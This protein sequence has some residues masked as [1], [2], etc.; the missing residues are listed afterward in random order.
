MIGGSFAL[1][2]KKNKLAKQ[3][4]GFDIDKKALRLAVKAHIIDDYILP[5]HKNG[6]SLCF[7]LI[8]IAC[9]LGK[10]DFI[11]NNII[12]KIS[13]SK[14][15]ISDLGS[16]KNFIFD[17]NITDNF[18]ATHPIAGSQKIGVKNAVIDLFVGKKLIICKA[19]HKSNAALIRITAMWQ[20][21]G[22]KIVYLN[23]KDHD[24]IYALVSHLPQLL[25]FMIKENFSLDFKSDDKILSQAY[26]LGDSSYQIWSDVF[27]LNK[28]N[29]DVFL[30]KLLKN[31]Q[32]LEKQLDYHDNLNWIDKITDKFALREIED[33]PK[34]KNIENNFENFLLHVILVTAFLKIKETESFNNYIG[35]GFEDFILPLVIFK[36]INKKNSAKLF[37]KNKISI[38]KKLLGLKSIISKF[39]GK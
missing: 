11:F 12:P 15:I 31:I 36:K 27:S 1:A 5:D 22:A 23:A 18:V 35:S 10:Y 20:K 26:R 9:P 29:I 17:L 37:A 24:K 8:M 13:N 3:I 2:I 4:W 33:Y 32:T 34:L 25:S 16:L 21:I 14:T 6:A 28:R 30:K 7:D 39:Y 38:L 19:S